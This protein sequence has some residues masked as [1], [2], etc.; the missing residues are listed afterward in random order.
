MKPINLFM[1]NLLAAV[2]IICPIASHANPQPNAPEAEK[3]VAE[4][5]QDFLKLKFGMFIHYNMPTQE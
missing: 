2:A 4:L 1:V 3:K 5:Q